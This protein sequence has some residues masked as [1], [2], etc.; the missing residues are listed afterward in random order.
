[1]FV[2]VGSNGVYY[3]KKIGR[4]HSA[5]RSKSSETNNVESFRHG[6]YE[7]FVSSDVSNLHDASSQ[8]VI[9]LINQNRKRAAH[10]PIFRWTAVVVACLVAQLP[11]SWH[12][13]AG[14]FVLIPGLLYAAAVDG[15]DADGRTTVLHYDLEGPAKFAFERLRQAVLC[16]NDARRL[17][18]VAGKWHEHDWKR[19]AGESETLCFSELS[20]SGDEQ[21]PYVGT[22]LMIP[23][24]ITRRHCFFFLPDRILVL[25]GEEYGA[26]SYDSLSVES[27]RLS[28][29]ERR[30]LT[31]DCEVIG[32]TWMKVNKDGSRDRRF[33]ENREL[34]IVQY[35][36]VKMHSDDGLKILIQ[37][38]NPD[39]ADQFV[40]R[41]NDAC[42]SIQER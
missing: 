42:G 5:E 34:P 1:V 6:Q 22:N 19:N 13:I 41:F 7:E 37:V 4:G 35:G 32:K 26:V 24:I 40:S 14:V 27:T 20:V 36:Y 3:R 12:W 25:Q 10:G 29:V 9:D 17:S 31:D 15:A 21:L 23:A 11:I 30:S 38:S 2:N 39:L 28:Y 16:L 8:E 18:V 33:V